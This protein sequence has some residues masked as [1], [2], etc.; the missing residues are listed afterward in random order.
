MVEVV[1]RKIGWLPIASRVALPTPEDVRLTRLQAGLTQTQAAQLVSTA[2]GQPYRTWQGYE[3][4]TGQPGHRTIPLAA[5]ELFLL[6]TDQH[7]TH[8]MVRRR[9]GQETGKP[10]LR[11]KEKHT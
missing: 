3:V 2:Q 4:E 11:K 1:H 5:W 6:I 8:R 7:P 9:G 10:I